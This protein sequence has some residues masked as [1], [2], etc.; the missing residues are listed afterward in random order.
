MGGRGSKS[1]VTTSGPAFNPSQYQM[2]Q[3]P[4][5]QA[6]QASQAQQ[7]NNQTFP[8]TDNSPFHQL[9]GGAAYFQSQTLTPD[10]VW[11]TLEY[12]RDDTGRADSWSTRGT[13]A[14]N[15]TQSSLH[16]M[17]Q[18][19]NNLMVY[20]A[21]NGL[22]ANS[23]MSANQE[24]TYRHL[25][26]AMHNLGQNLNLTRYDHPAFLNR[27]LSNTGIRNADYSKMSINQLK[28]VLTGVTYNEGKFLSTSYNNFRN[29][30]NPNT[31]NTFVNRAVRIEYKSKAST[32]AMMP[33]RAPGRDFGEIVLSPK[34]N[35]RIVDV[36]LDHSV[37]V[38]KQGTSG[39]S[40][41]SQ[42]VLVVETE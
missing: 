1:T 10:Q 29:I 40:N 28:Q 6:P 38:R 25:N 12:L 39:P 20:N 24:Y 37:K 7:A 23:G 42:L 33:G 34:T 14:Q 27:I 18:N 32:Q 4:P 8:D 9:H 30:T 5:Q 19:M 17:A 36:K 41:L 31:L 22:P 26:A 16:S 2:M 13:A 11:G 15:A 21:Q 35:C 3:E